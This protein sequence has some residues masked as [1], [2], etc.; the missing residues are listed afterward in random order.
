[1]RS[2]IG[3]EDQATVEL[4][5][6]KAL[7]SVRAP[8]GTADHYHRYLVLSFAAETRLFVIEGEEMEE[9]AEDTFTGFR[10]DAA[11]LACGNLSGHAR[12]DDF[13]IQATTREVRLIRASN[14][15]LV[16]S[17]WMPP[18]GKR[19]TVA[20]VGN[21]Q[22]LLALSGGQLCLLGLRGD[23]AQS[24]LELIGSRAMPQEIACLN[25]AE[26]TGAQS[27]GVVG[28]WSDISVRLLQ[29][30]SLTDMAVEHLGGD[31]PPR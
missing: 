30:P 19:I 7:W 2:G 22:V 24:T 12:V 31:I 15:S 3:I 21:D 25:L 1:V 4:P 29:L 8:S 14:G 26:S 23:G 6:I 10:T 18:S 13:A 20:A 28:L 5:G 27:L 17:P 9:A 16:G 11:T